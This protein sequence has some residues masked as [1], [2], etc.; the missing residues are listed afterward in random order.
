[1][2]WSYINTKFANKFSSEKE[3][4]NTRAM[5]NKLKAW[6]WFDDWLLLCGK[7]VDF[8]H[9][10]YN[11][12][13]V[14]SNVHEFTVQLT[15]YKDTIDGEDLRIVFFEG[16][17][18][19]FPLAKSAIARMTGPGVGRF[20]RWL[21]E[22][23][24]PAVV[25]WISTPMAD[26]KLYL[27][28]AAA[29][30]KQP[31]NKKARGAGDGV[32]AGEDGSAAA[33]KKRGKA[34]K[35]VAKPARKPPPPIC[36]TD[37][38]SST[39][40]VQLPSGLTS[41]RPTYWLDD[42][43]GAVKAAYGSYTFDVEQ[44]DAFA[45]KSVMYSIALEFCWNKGVQIGKERME[46]PAWIKLRKMLQT[47]VQSSHARGFDIS[48]AGFDELEAPA[49]ADASTDDVAGR[50]M[51]ALGE[52][53]A[54]EAG[55]ATYRVQACAVMGVRFARVVSN[56]VRTEG[57]ATSHVLLAPLGAKRPYRLAFHPG[58]PR[59]IR[60]LNRRLVGFRVMAFWQLPGGSTQ[61]KTKTRANG[62]V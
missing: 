59:Y 57:D 47:R 38:L 62:Q 36:I 48:A 60:L 19:M 11:T 44:R 61:F 23:S 25:G 53:L 29:A 1:L 13:V 16:S 22:K 51:A 31:P 50:L 45:V 18:M 3:F 34:G 26:S 46:V 43:I 58:H 6:G 12:R 4:L 17:K 39:V 42:V 37:T 24:S 32:A 30:A 33:A 9:K 20:P 27:K 8:G 49:A 28:E 56:V 15:K 41:E 54:E 55:L 7:M 14:I 10:Q 40:V 35:A 2:L 21:F 5:A 52:D